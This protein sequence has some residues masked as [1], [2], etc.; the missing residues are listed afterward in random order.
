MFLPSVG[1]WLSHL[2]S[3]SQVFHLQ[4]EDDYNSSTKFEILIWGPSDDYEIVTVHSR[5]I[6]F[7]QDN[8]L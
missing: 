1:P 2:T 3:E 4:N 8:G 5:N 7:S 6:L